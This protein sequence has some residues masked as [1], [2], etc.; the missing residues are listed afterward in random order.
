MAGDLETVGKLHLCDF[1]GSFLLKYANEALTSFLVK[2]S[3]LSRNPPSPRGFMELIFLSEVPEA[4]CGQAEA[5]PSTRSGSR[6]CWLQ[7]LQ[8][9]CSPL[10]AESRARPPPGTVL[11]LRT[12]ASGKSQGFCDHL[13]TL[14]CCSLTA[15][16]PTLPASVTWIWSRTSQWS[17]HQRLPLLQQVAPFAVA[18]A[19]ILGIYSHSYSG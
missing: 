7:G 5:V 1:T 16:V 10:P 2:G 15:A 6:F 8:R 3:S 4:H 14:W 18:V 12:A 19:P 13:L 17:C 11:C 9:G